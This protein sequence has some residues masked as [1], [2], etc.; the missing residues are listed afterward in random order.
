MAI[1]RK[2]LAVFFQ[3]FLSSATALAQSSVTGNIGPERTV[4]VAYGFSF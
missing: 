3:I 1:A 4:H 2:S